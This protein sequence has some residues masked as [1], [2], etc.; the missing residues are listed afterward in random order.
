MNTLDRKVFRELWLIRGQV[1]AIAMVIAAGLSTVIMSYSTLES[2]QQTRERY[3]QEYGFADLFASLKRAPIKL[4]QRIKQIPGVVDVDARVKAPVRISLENVDDPMQGLLVSIDHQAITSINKIYLREGRMPD[5]NLQTEVLVSEAF[6]QPHDLHAGDVMQI[7]VNGRKQTVH[8]VGIALSPEFIYQIAPGV[9]IPDFSRYG[10]IW[11]QREALETAYDMKGAFNDLS[12]K[13]TLEAKQQLIIQ[14]LDSLLKPYGGLGA[15]DR[16]LQVSH[17]FL[18]EEFKQLDSMG[19]S[20]SFI[21]LAVSIFLLNMV[22]G[23]IIASQRDIIA[24]LKAFGFS[25]RVIAFHYSKLI[26]LIVVIGMVIGITAGLILGNNLAKMYMEYYRFPYLDYQLQIK[27]IVYSAGVTLLAALLGTYISIR[28]AVLLQPAEAMR[29]EIPARYN[30]TFLESLGI[31][32]YLSQ[33]SRMVLRHFERHPIKAILSVLGTAFACGIMIVGTFFMDA[34]DYMVETEFKLSQREDLMVSLINPSS[35]K[36]I[37]ELNNI[38]GV[39]RVEPYRSAA[40][41]MY[42]G[43]YSHRTSIQGFSKNNHLHRVLDIQN[44]P[45]N[46]PETGILLTAFLAKK[47]QVQAGDQLTV[48]FLEG[49]RLT[50]QLQVAGVINQYIGLSGYMDIDALNQLMLEGR[51]VSGAYLAI[52]DGAGYNTQA[53]LKGLPQIAGVSEKK[54]LIESFYATVGDFI[55]T[56]IAFVTGLSVAI[57]FAVIYNNARITLAERTRELASLRVLGFTR[58]E[59]AYILLAEL[60]LITLLA[61]PVGLLI[62]YWMSYGFIVGLQ[63]DLFRI[64]FIIEMPTYAYAILVVICSAIIS[65]LIVRHK[66][67]QLDLVSVL[68]VKE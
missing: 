67:N 21:F 45:V 22:V 24:T 52:E 68:K 32:K 56:Y 17:H 58:G 19:S 51:V 61:I 4:V 42:A 16:E 55:L 26:A 15:Y 46:I 28:K 33:P 50:R 60:G 36:A 31:K 20:F 5:K 53:Y 18:S 11:M 13:L 38:E 35:Y 6:A 14:Q 39:L 37:Y 49:K 23:R 9:I 44:K 12:I 59:I 27:V 57:A 48:E 63:Q 34:M 30:V 62:G 10:I 54:S 41:K 3:Y 29:P 1:F 66:L 64:P 25:N 43:S 8:I 65:G 40:V 2:L 47:L 7:I